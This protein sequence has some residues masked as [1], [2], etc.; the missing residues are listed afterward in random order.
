[1]FWELI[2][3]VIVS[4]SVKIYFFITYFTKVLHKAIGALCYKPEGCRFE[5]RWGRFF[6]WPNP[7]M[8]LG[9]TQPLAEMSTRNL[10][11]VKGP[12]ACK[13]HS[14]TAICES[15]IK[16]MWEPRRVTPLCASTA[17]Y[18]DGFTFLHLLHKTTSEHL[19]RCFS[20]FVSILKVC[21]IF[22]FACWYCYRYSVASQ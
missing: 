2:M 22:L 11:G 12:Q 20:D 17:S 21:S 18:R 9:S 3:V 1:M 7:S 15:I 10:L 8:A 6:D 14:L 16:I 5:S 4:I 19:F 13:A